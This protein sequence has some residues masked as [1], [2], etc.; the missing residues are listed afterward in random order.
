MYENILQHR[1]KYK[2]DPAK[3][4]PSKGKAIVRFKAQDTKVGSIHIPPSSK[5]FQAEAEVFSINPLVPGDHDDV[6]AGQR[7]WI[8][9]NV[10]FDDSHLFEWDGYVY[11][12]IPVEAIQ[13]AEVAA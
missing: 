8:S 4:T 2:I 5:K 12:L 3:L 13:A 9:S 7:V 10:G 1:T 6:Y 11:A